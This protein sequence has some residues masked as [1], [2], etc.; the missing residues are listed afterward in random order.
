MARAV[1]LTSKSDIILNKLSEGLGLNKTQTVEIALTYILDNKIDPTD[2][3]KVDLGKELSK[4]HKTIIAFIKTQE[5]TYLRPSKEILERMEQT[6]I[7]QNQDLITQNIVRV[8]PKYKNLIVKELE[9]RF[10]QPDM[11]IKDTASKMSNVVE[12]LYIN[13]IETHA[14][15]KIRESR[16]KQQ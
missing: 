13:L 4:L 10:S 3:R 11:D 7:L 8:L 5:A 15:I 12:A 14:F 16:S 1:K 6:G 2:P 9:T